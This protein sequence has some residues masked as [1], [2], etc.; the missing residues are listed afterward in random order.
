MSTRETLA[1]WQFD[2]DFFVGRE[3]QWKDPFVQGTFA[4]TPPVEKSQEHFSLSSNLQT[5]W[6]K[7]DIKLLV[8]DVS[9]AHFHLHQPCENCTLPCRRRTRY[10]AWSDNFFARSIGRETRLMNGMIS[11]TG[12]LPQSS[13]QV[14]LSS[15]CIYGHNAEPSIGWRQGNDILFAGEEIRWDEIFD[16]LKGEMI[17]KRRAQLGFTE[18]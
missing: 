17:L 9:R 8:Q 12:R 5:T 14:G 16:K 1:T 18:K 13:T 2:Q 7:L 3:C 4:A 15:P 10:Q 6:S 11:R